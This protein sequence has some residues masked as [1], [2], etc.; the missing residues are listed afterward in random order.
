[1]IAILTHESYFILR[2]VTGLALLVYLGAALLHWLKVLYTEEEQQ[3]DY[4]RFLRNSSIVICVSQAVYL[5]VDLF[6]NVQKLEAQGVM[7]TT[8]KYVLLN[9]YPLIV[10]I[11]IFA[12]ILH[13]LSQCSK[14]RRKVLHEKVSGIG[15]L[16]FAA[17]PAVLLL[18][19]SF[20]WPNLVDAVYL[21][22]KGKDILMNMQGMFFVREVSV[23]VCL[24]VFMDFAISGFFWSR[25]R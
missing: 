9:G 11:G 1:M 22:D 5:L 17:I 10:P 6:N 7:V 16:L 25:K 19:Q 20:Y 15:M 12:L 24:D 21:A 4:Y 23:Y 14:E 3:P 8:W 2:V 18:V 13:R